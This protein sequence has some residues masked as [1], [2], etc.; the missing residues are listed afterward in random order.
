[1]DP[2]V[3]ILRLLHVGLGV[4]WVGAVLFVTFL[5]LPAMGEAGPAAGAVM[6]GL[7]KRRMMEIL[8]LVAVITI[9]SGFWLY[10]RNAGGI[11]GWAGTRVGIAL[12]T[13]GLLATIALVLGFVVVRPASI[14]ATTLLAEVTQVPE[15]PERAS[16]MAAAQEL[17]L[18]SIKWSRIIAVLLIV[19]TALMAVA[20]NL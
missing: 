8:P 20:Q 6:A 9:I 5:L 7:Q 1:M 13:G 18:R 10:G 2:L 3:L 17:R 11:D 4:F 14:R 15:G 12:G 19:T 16:R